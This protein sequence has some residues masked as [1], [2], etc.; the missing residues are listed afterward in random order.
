VGGFPVVW[1]GAVASMLVRVMTKFLARF[2]LSSLPR[3][4]VPTSTGSHASTLFLSGNIQ[5]N[6]V[7]QLT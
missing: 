4:N 2:L 3:E 5:F 1:C 7:F 6:L